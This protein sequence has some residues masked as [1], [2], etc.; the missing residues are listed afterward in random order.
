MFATHPDPGGGRVEVALSVRTLT[1]EAF[2]P[3]G[4]VIERPDHDHDAAGPGWSWWA[5]IV[6]LE[7]DGR[8]WGVGYLD[9]SP[10]A[11]RFDWA[12]RHLRS[13]EA[14]VPIAGSCLVYV[15]PPEQPNDPGR[16]PTFERFEVFRVPS[17]SG[18]VMD[19]GGMARSAARRWRS[20]S[21]DRAATSGNRPRRRDAGAVRGDARRDRAHL[22]EG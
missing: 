7:G 5:E 13:L 1:A 10:S 18:V 11:A 22:R 8:P 16:L 21:G 14:I 15:A 19:A 12:E 20:G 6:T 3:F 9:L 2:A 4:L 17:G